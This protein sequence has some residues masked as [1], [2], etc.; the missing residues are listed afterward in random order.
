MISSI[1]FGLNLKLCH[2][3]T[4]H[5]FLRF[6]YAATQLALQLHQE[7]TQVVCREWA[8]SHAIGEMDRATPDDDDCFY[9][10][11]K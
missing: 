2:C 4:K 8:R 6:C 9:Y 5:F 7:R 3:E 1:I 11:K 10:Y